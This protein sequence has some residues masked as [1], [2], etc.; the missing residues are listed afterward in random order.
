MKF[1]RAAAKVFRLRSL[2]YVVLPVAAAVAVAWTAVPAFASGAS[3]VWV[4]N[5]NNSGGDNHSW[6]DPLNWFPSGVPG[7]GDSVSIAA[8][9]PNDCSAHVDNVPTATLA[10]LSIAQS[11]ALCGVSINGGNL[12]VTGTFGWDGGVIAT[13]ITLSSGAAGV[14]HGSNSRLNELSANMD[15]AGTLTLSGVTGSGASN[16][17]A[18][19]IDAP[20]VLHILAGGS[21]A[22]S[23]TN[24]ITFLSCCLN[25]AKIVNDG[26]IAV[27]GGDFNVDAVEVDQNGT[28]AA[29]SGGRLVTTGAP[30]TAGTGADYT[31]TGGWLI[32]DGAQ[33][34][35]SGTQTLGSNF[36]LELGPLSMNA[37][38]QLGGTA[39]F[40]GTGTIDWTGGTIEGNITIAHRVTVNASGAHTDN[41]KRVLAGQDGLSGNAAAVFTNHGT[42][43]FDQGAGVL[44]AWN[45]EFV[46]AA[47]GV[48]SLAPGTQ[49]TTL[50]CCINPNR[51]INHG[52]LRIPAAGSSSPAV[53]DGV[54]YQSDATTAIAKSETLQLDEAPSS[55]TSATVNGGGTLMVTAPTAVGGTVTVSSGT[56]L[57]LQ[58]GG[59]LD[60]T[61]TVSGAGSLHW[62]GGSMS[63]KVTVATAGTT[64]TGTDQ[65]YVSNVNG[66]TT[67]SA[68]TLKS[69]TT[70]GAGTGAKHNVLNV[71]QSTLTLGSTTAAANFVDIYAGTLVNTGTFTV[72]PGSAGTVTRSGSG[73]FINRGRVTVRTGN[74]VVGGDYDQTAGTT[75]VA[76]GAS[77]SRVFVTQPITISGGELDGTG[78]IAAGV[79]NAGGTVAPAGKDTGTLHITGSYTQAA[80]GTL[81]VD[82][83]AKS[84]DRLAV[85]GPA[86]ISG[87][88]AARDVGSYNP[89]AGAK[90]VVLTGSTVT[91]SPSCTSTSGTGSSTHHWQF[92]H[93][94]TGVFLTRRSG[95]YRC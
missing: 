27:S 45:A 64:I 86:T 73:P 61:A 59:S 62:T 78:T 4:G 65:K 54:A 44:T 49:V 79:S 56:K 15:V 3:Y 2:T 72:S 29:S 46:N 90:Y 19:R 94:A 14:I 51:I 32:E 43:S 68:V 80:N 60:G 6:T 77:L 41:G 8:P 20:N 33:A 83:A 13:P 25:P 81:A 52:A 84:R 69:P 26:T 87:T 36:H 28:L 35:M 11:P 91:G 18:M 53:M 58:T 5:S 55:L 63:G 40:A 22:S 47:D 38:V 88:L 74:L 48:L 30:L 42:V 24:D 34:R 57:A 85:G 31:G 9:A 12:T 50:G 17:G 23:G 16:S 92:S 70:I 82:L 89:A 39:T 76:D 37:G 10:G 67:P 75:T 93:T 21:L 95:K 1:S 71:G 66:G 7:N